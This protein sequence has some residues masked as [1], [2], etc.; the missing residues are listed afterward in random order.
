MEND[1]CL[2]HKTKTIYQT[3]W[4]KLMLVFYYQRSASCDEKNSEKTQQSPVQ[5]IQ[6]TI[7]GRN[8][9][10]DNGNTNKFWK[11]SR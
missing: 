11:G 1:I 2:V 6:R 9:I 7:T 3:Y 8:V 5:T 4:S 10:Q